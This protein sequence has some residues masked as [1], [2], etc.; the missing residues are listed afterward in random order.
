MDIIHSFAIEFCTEAE[1]TQKL[2]SRIPVDK[3]AWQPHQKSMSLGRLAMHI[4]ELPERIVTCI[5]NDYSDV[6]GNNFFPLIPD[7]LE[8][9]M[10]TFEAMYQKGL[11]ALEN[12]NEEHLQS[13]WKIFDNGQ[14]V[15]EIPRSV[16]IR[17]I[18]N[19]IIHHR[20]QLTVF[21]RLLETPLPGIY[22]PTADEF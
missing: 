1:N 3:L 13:N 11:H 17:N 8:Q 5:Q 6:G 2:L 18:F 14:L 7:R 4:A 10:E 9:V 16:A 15:Y 19:H 20:G 21:L 12:T 22:G